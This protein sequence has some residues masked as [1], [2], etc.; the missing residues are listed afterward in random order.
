LSKI[1]RPIEYTDEVIQD[2][3]QRFE[4]YIDNTDIPIVAEFAYKN[5]IRRQTLYER[6]EFSDTMGKCVDKK[7]AQLETLGLFNVINSSMAQFSLK[8]LGWRDK[9]D[10]NMST[11]K[12]LSIAIEVVDTDEDK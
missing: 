11:D 4:E 12:P 6:G 10:L 8:Q 1:G 9:Q 3:K 5:D 2:I 7:E